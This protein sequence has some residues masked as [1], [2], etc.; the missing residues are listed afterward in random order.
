LNLQ[1]SPSLYSAKQQYVN[2]Y[3]TFPLP[4]SPKNLPGQKQNL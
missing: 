2:F 3:P 4:I 1:V